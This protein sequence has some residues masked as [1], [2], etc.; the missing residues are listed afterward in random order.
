MTY[1]PEQ[2]RDAADIYERWV[3]RS[4]NP[5]AKTH[6]SRTAAQLRQGA[7]AVERVGVLDD[8]LT[9]A[10]RLAAGVSDHLKFGK[11]SCASCADNI[12]DFENALNPAPKETK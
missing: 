4:E 6:Y 12:Q 10:R 8:V 11:L 7:D 1:T 2:M 3:T 5:T 9:A